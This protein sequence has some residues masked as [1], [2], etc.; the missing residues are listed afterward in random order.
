MTTSRALVVCDGVRSELATRNRQGQHGAEDKTHR[1][2]EKQDR[3]RLVVGH[4]VAQDQPQ[5]C[6]QCHA[7]QQAGWTHRRHDG[8]SDHVLV[9]INGVRKRGR[10]R[11]KQKSVETHGQQQAAVNEHLD[12]D[13]LQPSRDQNSKTEGNCGSREVGNDEHLSARHPVDHNCGKRSQDRER[14]QRNG[15]HDGDRGRIRLPLGREEHIGGERDLKHSVTG[16]DGDAYG[17][18]PPEVSVPQELPEA[19]KHSLAT[20]LAVGAG[21]RLAPA[22]FSTSLVLAL[23][24]RCASELHPQPCGY[25]FRYSESLSFFSAVDSSASLAVSTTS[26]LCPSREVPKPE[27]GAWSNS[28]SLAL[29]R[30]DRAVRL[31][32]PSL[33][34]I[35]DRKVLRHI[36]DEGGEGGRIG[37][38]LRAQALLA[39]WP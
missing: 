14:Q 15:Q 25:F 35:V 7:D 34:F 26:M 33:K 4:H 1:G 27:I 18:Q 3:V 19:P 37:D 17:Q 13:G 8:V 9:R 30:S 12:A 22:R 31:I 29:S 24:A 28:M 2:D 38:H 23:L 16:L 11:R 21:H 10:Q 6:G 32:S 36:A 20:R 39:R 5:W